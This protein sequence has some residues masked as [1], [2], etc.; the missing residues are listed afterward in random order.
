MT[1]EELKSQVDAYVDEVWEDVVSDMDLLIQVE[2]VEDKD[3]AAPGM[4]FGPNPK[5]AL[6]RALAIAKRLGLEAHDC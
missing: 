6:V 2:S 5:E 4:P 1:D 3:H